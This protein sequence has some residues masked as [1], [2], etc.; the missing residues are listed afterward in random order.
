MSSNKHRAV[1]PHPVR[2]ESSGGSHKASRLPET[3][4]MLSLG[5]TLIVL[6]AVMVLR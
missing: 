5:T 4:I 2:V 6:A 3:L 1:E